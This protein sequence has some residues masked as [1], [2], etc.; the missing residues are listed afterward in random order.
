MYLISIYIF[1]RPLFQ[2][3]FKNT[4]FYKKYLDLLDLYV[5]LTDAGSRLTLLRYNASKYL[6]YLTENL[7]FNPDANNVTYLTNITDL[8]MLFDQTMMA[9]GDV[10]QEYEEYQDEIDEYEFFDEE[11]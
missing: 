5:N 9:Y 3:S 8:L 6:M 4:V 2:I 7:T 11:R 1:Y 10:F